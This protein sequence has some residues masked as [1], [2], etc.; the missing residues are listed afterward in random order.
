M[1]ITERL[2]G[3]LLSPLTSAVEIRFSD[4]VGASTI[5]QK[6]YPV[7]QQKREVKDGKIR[8]KTGSTMAFR[9]ENKKSNQVRA[10]VVRDFRERP[11]TSE[12]ASVEEAYKDPNDSLQKI[13][14]TVLNRGSRTKYIDG[15][16]VFSLQSE[17]KNKT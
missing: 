17:K 11:N 13:S 10:I 9:I 4:T 1:S 3:I 12:R 2:A 14:L 16:G 15:I 7:Q 8:V 5:Y 6:D